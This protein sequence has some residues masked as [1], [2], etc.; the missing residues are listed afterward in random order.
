MTK[1]L[2]IELVD[3]IPLSSNGRRYFK[4]EM[5]DGVHVLLGTNGSGKTSIVNEC[6]P[7]ATDPSL[8]RNTGSKKTIYEHEH[9]IY[10]VGFNASTGKHTLTVTDENGEEKELNEGGT[11]NVQ[12]QLIETIFK[13]TPFIRQLIT[14]EIKFSELGPQKR[15]EIFT[16]MSPVSFDYGLEFYGKAKNMLSECSGALKRNKH[17]LV[18]ELAKVMNE[19][20]YEALVAKNKS[21]HHEFSILMNERSRINKSSSE[22]SY[23]L[24]QALE[25]LKTVSERVLDADLNIAL[26]INFNSVE[27]LNSLIVEKREQISSLDALLRDRSERYDAISKKIKLVGVDGDTEKNRLKDRIANQLTKRQELIDAL[28]DTYDP[29]HYGSITRAMTTD[30][31]SML[32]TIF[33]D[34]GLNDDLRF[35]SKSYQDLQSKYTNINASLI[36][37]NEQMVRIDTQIKELDRHRENGTIHCPKC[38]HAWI[39]G[40][41]PH[42]Y[43]GLTKEYE[44]ML[45]VRTGYEKE[46]P[47]VEKELSEMKVFFDNYRT[48]C[49]V[50]DS[51]GELFH[52]WNKLEEDHLVFKHP[53]HALA[54]VERFAR[55]A[56]TLEL[57]VQIDASL[58]TDLQLLEAIEQID[59]SNVQ[60]EA[61]IL[62]D[63]EKEIQSFTWRLQS[64]RNALTIMQSHLQLL[65]GVT[66]HDKANIEQLVSRIDQLHEEQ[67][68][69]IRQEHIGQLIKTIQSQL[70]INEEVLSGVSHQRGV[71]DH[72]TEQIQEL[73]VEEVAI[74]QLLEEISPNKGLIAEGLMSYINSILELTNE[75]IARVWTYPF[76][77]RPCAVDEDGEVGLTYRFP[78]DIGDGGMAIKDIVQGSKA[79][80]EIT[81]LAFR[82]VAMVY[83]GLGEF[84]LFLD[85]FGE[86][87]DPLHRERGTH[88]INAFID[89]MSFSQIFIVTHFEE[90][91]ATLKNTNICLLDDRNIRVN[92]EHNTHVTLN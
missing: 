54:L 86:G 25:Q 8:Y 15:R 29:E 77:I 1:I 7:C 14:G 71:I 84:I 63:L 34:M 33:T 30:L 31:L 20:E 42:N 26:D 61:Q 39:A 56:Q 87:F 76:V 64:E 52:L 50:R 27:E 82:V 12:Q 55:D 24:Q 58:K 74:K 60:K 70:A 57:V 62:I 88:A 22:L 4:W 80:R 38:Q 17:Q 45:D 66:V 40:F 44:R 90:N 81:N 47:V 79:Q 36:K 89:Q 43:E 23:E 69:A 73:E 5:T 9:K 16:A 32:T 37:L 78:I 19:Q 2:S 21:L 91:F 13:I 68:E 49:S 35:N 3:F 10:T 11:K 65:T 67:I 41:D 85:E 83:L 18:T 46:I 28:S 51:R 72:L 53:R 75:I 92:I 6:V 59:T 48:Y